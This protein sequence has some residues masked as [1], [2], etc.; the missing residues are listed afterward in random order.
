[1]IRTRG[2]ALLAALGS[3]SFANAQTPSAT[4]SA[5]AVVV[6]IGMS[7]EAIGNLTAGPVV[8]GVPTL[9][10]PT[11]ANAGVVMVTGNPNAYVLITFTLPTVLTNTQALPGSAIP[12]T[13]NAVSAR[14]NRRDNDPAAGTPFDPAIGAQGRFGPPASPTMYVWLGST[15]NPPPD[16]KP[17]IYQS[18]VVISLSYP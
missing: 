18:T 1:V 11:D 17:G 4:V 7:F 15:I 6:T 3:A 9:I 5:D 12:I 16:A 8:K 2:L 13:F 14:W 10:Q